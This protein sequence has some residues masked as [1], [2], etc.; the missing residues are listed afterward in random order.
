M[1][2]V[3]LVGFEYSGPPI[4]Q[5]EIETRGLCRPEIEPRL[6][7]DALYDYDVIIIYPETYSHFIFG[8]E[9]KYSHSEHEL[10]ELKRANNDHDLD[11][12][13][14]ARDREPELNAALKAGSRVIWLIAPEKRV[15]FFGTRSSYLGYLNNT[16]IHMMDSARVYG[17]KSRKLTIERRTHWLKGYFE[18]LQVDGWAG[19]VSD[20]P[21]THSVLA[22]TPEGYILGAELT[23]D[24]S[25]AWLLT[26]PRSTL[27]LHDLIR[28]TL[29]LDDDVV[30]PQHYENI[31]LCHATEDKPFVRRIR[32]SLEKHGVNKVWV[33]EGEILIG[34]SLLRKIESGIAKAKYF[35]IVLSPTSVASNWVKKELEIAMNREIESDQV[36]VLPLLYPNV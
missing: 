1:K 32:H 25:R 11:T 36:V 14:W 28:K 6:A 8:K 31:F 13:F 20:L 10:G 3:L 23:I 34:D 12:I 35:G 9:G 18:R 24:G 33:D 7:A 5:V 27:G 21:G 26:C 30:T 4:P 17:K 16:V 2:K 15:R 29:K 22:T 19:C